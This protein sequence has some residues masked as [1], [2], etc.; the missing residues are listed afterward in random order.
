[1]G[2]CAGGGGGGAGLEEETCKSIA[3][4]TGRDSGCTIRAES[5]LL[6]YNLEDCYIL[7]PGNGCQGS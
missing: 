4:P 2:A 1:M 6:A 3:C 7:K 5:N